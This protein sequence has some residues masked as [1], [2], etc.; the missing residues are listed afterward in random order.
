MAFELENEAVLEFVGFFGEDGGELELSVGLLDLLAD[1]FVAL[2]GDH[3][4]LL[5]RALL[6]V[7]VNWKIVADLIVFLIE[8]LLKALVVVGAQRDHH[9]P[10]PL[11][12]LLY[13]LVLRLLN[14]D[15]FESL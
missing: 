13:I 3:E 9:P 15:H 12:F 2:R 8:E 1:V 5:E 14:A 6:R 11:A 10:L 7:V 4:G